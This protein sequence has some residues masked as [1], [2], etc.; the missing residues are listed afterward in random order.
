VFCLLLVAGA[1]IFEEQEKAREAER[2]VRE[3]ELALAESRKTSEGLRAEIDNLRVQAAGARMSEDEIRDLFASQADMDTLANAGLTIEEA[4]SLVPLHKFMREKSIIPDEV[5]E[6]VKA[7]DAIQAAGLT[8]EEASYL[9]E[10]TALLKEK[11]VDGKKLTELMATAEALE[12]EEL[13]PEEARTLAKA[14][15]VLRDLGYAD[16]ENSEVAADELLVILKKAKPSEGNVDPHD[17]PPII[18]LSE[19]D[20]YS[21]KVG[22]AELTEEFRLKLLQKAHEIAD[23]AK[24]YPIDIIE[25]IGHT[26]EQAMAGDFSNMDRGLQRVLQGGRPVATL[27]PADNAGLGLARALSVANVL[28]GIPELALFDILP[29]SGG[30]LILPGY[31]LTDGFQAGDAPARR[32]IEIRVRR[33]DPA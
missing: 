10:L 31:T 12:A 14:T 19:V 18:T 27:H 9:S 8:M 1:L 6:L 13:A 4:V 7:R 29:M 15:A 21:F 16:P 32:R 20:G 22:S 26:D 28:K 24:R 17:W 25:I 5:R 3:A 23:T 2:R 33:R 11:K 30:Q